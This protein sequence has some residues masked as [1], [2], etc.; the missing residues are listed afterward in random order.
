MKLSLLQ[1]RMRAIQ[2]KQQSDALGAYSPARLS[3]SSS[4]L[5]FF[6]FGAYVQR[7][8]CNQTWCSNNVCKHVDDASHA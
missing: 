2:A 8:A 5:N 6:N 1:H 7:E 4:G 3:E